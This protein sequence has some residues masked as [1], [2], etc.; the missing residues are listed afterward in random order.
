[1]I[2]WPRK[3]RSERE[4]VLKPDTGTVGSLPLDEE[5]LRADLHLKPEAH[6]IGQPRCESARC[7]GPRHGKAYARRGVWSD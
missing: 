6:P 3:E 5:I 4:R 1:M 2:E 7:A